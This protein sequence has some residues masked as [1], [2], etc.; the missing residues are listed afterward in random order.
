MDIIIKDFYNQGSKWIEKTWTVK[1]EITEHGFS[2][3]LMQ[4]KNPKQKCNDWI[5]KECNEM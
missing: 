2:N 5:S 3:A 1:E 4:I